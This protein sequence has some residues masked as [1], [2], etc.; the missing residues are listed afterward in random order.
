MIMYERMCEMKVGL[1][2]GTKVDTLMGENILKEKNIDVISESMANTCHEQSKMQYYEKDELEKLFIKKSKK[3]ISE[4]ADIIFIYCNSLSSSIDYI[5]ISQL[6]NVKIITPLETYKTL[7]DDSKNIAIIA[8]NGI[9][10]YTIDKIVLEHHNNKSTISIG[11]LSL[12]EQIEM[13][14]SPDKISE[15]LNL[16][17]FLNYLENIKSQE[18]KIDSLILGCTHFY[19]MKNWFEKNSSLK[20]IDPTED[21][22]N[23]IMK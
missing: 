17:G 5:K 8:A 19:Y 4:N 16:K 6:L 11:M 21:M 14:Y 3:L 23:K 1:I 18:N 2:A 15:N 13:K 9:S 7:P 22:I 20:I 10:A 12:T